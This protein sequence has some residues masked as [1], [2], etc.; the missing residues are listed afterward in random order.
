[1]EERE[2]EEGRGSG[3]LEGGKSESRLRAPQYFSITR[4]FGGSQAVVWREGGRREEWKGRREEERKGWREEKRVGGRRTGG[5]ERRDEGR[6][7]GNMRSTCPLR[8][9][10]E[11]PRV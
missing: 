7:R 2:R 5:G 8:E 6:E 10:R 1:M 9:S 11:T 3:R 4:L